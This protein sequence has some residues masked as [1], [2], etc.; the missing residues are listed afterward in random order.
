MKEIRRI[1]GFFVVVL[2]FLSTGYLHAQVI[3]GAVLAGMN[4]TQVDGDEIYGF[5]KVGI[6]LGAA[7]IVPFADKWEASI[8][9]IFS[10]KGS[11][12]GPHNNDSLT[13][14]Y[15]LRLNY[16]EV[17]V[18]VHFN[19]KNKVIFGA[20]FSWGRLVNIEEYEHGNR[21]E[22]TTLNNG[23]YSKNDY[24]ALVDLRFRIYKQL[25]FNVR[26]A[27]SLKKIRTRVYT[28]PFS[29]DSWTRDQYNNFWTFRLIYI[30]NEEFSERARQ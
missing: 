11:Y 23:P 5:N 3:K 9:T 27:Y 16:L 18:L 20:G 28:P 25:K 13:G 4:L 30:F 17:P 7:A 12:Q 29:N 24:N 22:S 14:E 10:Q 2:V 21:V 15:R 6:N 1:F 19:D 26:Y 8:E